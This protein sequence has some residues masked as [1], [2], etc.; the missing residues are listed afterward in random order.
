MQPEV[1]FAKKRHGK[2]W[3]LMEELSICL[4]VLMWV[5]KCMCA[6]KG[7]PIA[8]QQRKS[9]QSQTFLYFAS[10]FWILGVSPPLCLYHFRQG[11]SGVKMNKPPIKRHMRRTK[12]LPSGPLDAHVFH[13]GRQWKAA[14]N[15]SNFKYCKNPECVLRSEPNPELCSTGGTF[16]PLA[17]CGTKVP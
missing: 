11:R 10:M 14:S 8:K 7:E 15:I 12:S 17:L 13:S 9:P 3:L 4:W 6:M 5:L 16:T 2:C 1:P